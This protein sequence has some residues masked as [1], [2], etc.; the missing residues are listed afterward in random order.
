MS[1]AS[2]ARVTCSVS[3][4]IGMSE[5]NTGLSFMTGQHSPHVA[6]H[7]SLTHLPADA[8]AIPETDSGGP[9]ASPRC[10]FCG[11]GSRLGSNKK[12]KITLSASEQVGQRPLGL[13]C[14]LP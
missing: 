2:M 3:L 7:C 13:M 10:R 11:H 8:Q 1:L 14:F 4:L 9:L 5:W 12:V 6:F